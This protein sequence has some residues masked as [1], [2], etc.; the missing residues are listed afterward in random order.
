L[1]ANGNGSIEPSEIPAQMRPF[2]EGRL[3]D[4]G[5]DLSR[6]IPLS[7]LEDLR[8]SREEGSD[9]SG[10]DDP[11]MDIEEGVPGFGEEIVLDL[12]LG[13]GNG[14][15]T[16]AKPIEKK[17][18]A[19]AIAQ[20]DDMLRRYDRNGNKMLDREEWGGVPWRSNPADA[21]KNRDGRLNREELAARAANSNDRDRNR[22][23]RDS[24]GGGD[25]GD[26]GRGGFLGEGG[27]GGFL[28]MMGGSTLRRYDQNGNG[29][30]E[31]DEWSQMRGDPSAAD[32]NKDGKI[33]EQELSEW[34]PEQGR[35]GGGGRGGFGMFFGGGDESGG[36]RGAWGNRGD[37]GGE[38]RG[39]SSSDSQDG[40]GDEA[41]KP[42]SY[43]LKSTSERIAEKFKDLPSW[44][45]GKD[46]DGDGQVS[47]SEYASTWTNSTANQFSRLD[48]NGDGV[49]TPSEA[50]SDG[51]SNSSRED[52]R[53]ERFSSRNGRRGDYPSR[54]TVAVSTPETNGES[55]A[56]TSTGES[57][58]S[59]PAEAADSTPPA[60]EPAD[61]S[62]ANPRV[63][64]Y[65]D[66]LI[67]K[68]DSNKNGV[69]EPSEWSEMGGSMKDA[70]R[71]GDNRITKDELIRHNS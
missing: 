22:G 3:R 54:E 66:G 21:D 41:E 56:S 29:V 58:V 62:P 27:P 49:I 51:D 61:A 23:D 52:S 11:A 68:Y 7:R 65:V 67:S 53:A 15:D 32:K 63:I 57:A 20:A 31:R 14:S 45:S 55:E 36:G 43:R 2:I 8:R 59:P 71:N 28:A 24:D 1:D 33:T 70:D 64:K 38:S 40:K 44:F 34:L 6:P 48:H 39:S 25:R 60:D 19:N 46:S 69:L 13:F 35:N 50:L 4:A 17:Y 26:R 5:I 9:P 47:M 37:G 16:A 10:S 18:D 12:V 42:K 30:L